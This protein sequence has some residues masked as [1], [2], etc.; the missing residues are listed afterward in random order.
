[1][2]PLTPL[3][4]V[5]LSCALL[6]ASPSVR[7]QVTEPRVVVEE[8]PCPATGT[9]RVFVSSAGAVELNGSHTTLAQLSATIARRGTGLSKFCYS[10]AGD[11]RSENAREVA[12]QALEMI[13]RTGLPID[14]YE[15]EHFQR[16]T[17]VAY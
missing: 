3:V 14:F 4:V 10:N 16:R 7:C 13:A 8:W 1:M 5:L 6:A 17:R 2:L 15:D 9:L 11:P 12:L